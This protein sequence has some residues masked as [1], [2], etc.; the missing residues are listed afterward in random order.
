MDK[1]KVKDLPDRKLIRMP[2]YDYSMSGFY[3]VTICTC[4]RFPYFGAIDKG[5]MTLN[6]Y[7]D[8]AVKHWLSIPDHCQDV[9]LYEYV[10]MPNHI[11]GI[12]IIN[13]EERIYAF[14]TK[15]E[16]KCNRT[17]MLL[18]KVIQQYKSSVTR[19]ICARSN[20]RAFRWQKSYYDRI[21]RNENELNCIRE[22]IINNPLKWG[23]DHE[24]PEGKP[25]D[26]EKKFWKAFS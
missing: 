7:G 17:Q 9:E 18:S 15:N 25:D 11:H 22:Y 20:K 10:V 5:Q 21:I 14:P 12:V 13:N 26:K 24:N 19:D 2:S 16:E 6:K 1:D 3:F 4:N 8:V 23:F